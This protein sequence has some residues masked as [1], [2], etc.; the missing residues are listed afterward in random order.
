MSGK[1]EH[2]YSLDDEST[3][4]NKKRRLNSTE[5]FPTTAFM[6]KIISLDVGGVIHRTS[7]DTLQVKKD[8]IFIHCHW[9]WLKFINMEVFWLLALK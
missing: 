5:C 3:Q 4:A 7:W 2:I 8:Q 6:N 1:V 9:L